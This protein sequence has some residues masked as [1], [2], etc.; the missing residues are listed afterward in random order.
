MSKKCL[1][2]VVAISVELMSLQIFSSPETPCIIKTYCSYCKFNQ[3][4]YFGFAHK[5]AIQHTRRS[6]SASA[7]LQTHTKST[8]APLW[9]RARHWSSWRWMTSSPADRALRTL[10]WM[11]H[12]GSRSRR[13]R[14]RSTEPR[15]RCA[16]RSSRT[17]I[18]FL[19]RQLFRTGN[20]G[21]LKQE[22][23]FVEN[24]QK[25]YSHLLHLHVVITGKYTY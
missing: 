8:P 11:L 19:P 13:F 25:K 18:D 2:S 14:R 15:C 24:L 21:T 22:T 6:H 17:P 12:C 16:R 3:N 20:T 1:L 23:I 5:R 7:S 4:K 9:T 10:R